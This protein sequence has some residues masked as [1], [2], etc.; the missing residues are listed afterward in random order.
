MR[1]KSIVIASI[2]LMILI[3]F[4]CVYFILTAP[5]FAGDF[6][7]NDF[8]ENIENENFQTDKNYGEI[9]DYRTAANAGKKAIAERF[10]NSDGSIFEWM[11]CSVQY[12]KANDVYYVRTYHIAP[13]VMGGAYDVIIQSDGTVLAVWGEK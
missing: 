11:G 8:R 1:K 12:D 2:V 3:V 4:L 7:L 9:T 13:F 10:E 6:T 5:K